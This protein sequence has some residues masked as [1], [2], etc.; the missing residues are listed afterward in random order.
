MSSLGAVQVNASGKGPAVKIGTKVDGFDPVETAEKVKEAAVSST[1]KNSE[2]IKNNNAVVIPKLKE[3]ENRVAALKQ[4]V[5]SLKNF[6]GMKDNDQ[7][8]NV[9]D[10][11]NVDYKINGEPAVNFLSITSNSDE[12]DKTFGERSIRILKLAKTDARVTHAFPSVLKNDLTAITSETE[13]MGLTGTISINGIDVSI[14][15]TDSLSDIIQNINGAKTGA[16]ARFSLQ[17]S[18]YK[19]LIQADDPVTPITFS[20][21]DSAIFTDNFGFDI[22]ATN[23]QDLQALVEVDEFDPTATNDK[24][25]FS[26]Y[27]DENQSSDI[28]PGATLKFLQATGNS[29]DGFD[30]IKINIFRRSEDT[31]EKIL[32]VFQ[33]FNSIKQEL[34]R[35]SQTDNE[36]NPLHAG[37]DLFRQ[38]IIN[39]L[40]TELTS[41]FAMR[42]LNPEEGDLL[43]WDDFGIKPVI[44][45]GADIAKGT[46]LID[47]STLRETVDSKF[48]KVKK[49]FGVTHSITGQEGVNFKLWSVGQNLSESITNLDITV[50]Y[51]RKLDGGYT[52]RMQ[53]TGQDSGTYDIYDPKTFEGRE[54]TV[55]EGISLG[56]SGPDLAT[57]SSISFTLKMSQGIADRM[58]Y[59][60]EDIL[61]DQPEDESRKGDFAQERAAIKRDNDKNAKIINDAND[62]A[63]HIV[64]SW[65]AKQG[66]LYQ[67]STKYEQFS[68]FLDNM[69]KAMERG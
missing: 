10:L 20:G 23:I 60:L 7:V 54:G 55:F 13:Q 8:N 59:R 39:R 14:L 11:A 17:G 40:N 29:N 62:R 68:K 65:S 28:I 18:E 31:A 5:S 16:T 58:N 50:T 4:D 34:N 25:T 57:E 1:T 46:Y 6:I 49:F 44:P 15:A 51:S 64:K 37:A 27:L 9:Y 69:Y 53:G 32:S 26:Y 38:K 12:I 52:V 22:T 45:K 36:G 61:Y 24:V 35:N 41:M 42:P 47:H 43:D 63:E 19:L 21:A 30:D 56:Y 66:M 33:N 3:L 48:D 2:T 67:Y